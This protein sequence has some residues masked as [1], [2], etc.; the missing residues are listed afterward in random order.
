MGKQESAGFV[1]VGGPSLRMGQDKALLEFDGTPLAQR[2]AGLV[3]TVAGS[4]SLVGSR[5]KFLHLGWPVLEDII[6]GLGP[7]GGLH[8]ALTHTAARWNLVVGC[9]LPLLTADFL[10][11]L[12]RLA[13][14]T[15][16]QAV[17]PVSRQSAYEPLAA[18]YRKDCLEAVQSAI[19]RRQLRMA[20]LLERLHLRPVP[21]E[22]WRAFD[23]DG[24]LFHNVNTPEELE[25]ARKKLAGC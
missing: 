25:S 22:E 6:P 5:R 23:P 7:L 21:P 16:A 10:A 8:A 4:A 20:A 18:V 13:V 1:L 11:L 9:D 17:V 12:L 19:D 24:V 2:L 14:E 3:A 15:E